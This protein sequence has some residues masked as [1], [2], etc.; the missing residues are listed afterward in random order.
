MF[1]FQTFKSNAIVLPKPNVSRGALYFANAPTKGLGWVLPYYLDLNNRPLPYSVS[2]L[3][4]F[5]GET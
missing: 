3:T 4:D 1:A 2:L 5:K